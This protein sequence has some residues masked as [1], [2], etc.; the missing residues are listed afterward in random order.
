MKIRRKADASSPRKQAVRLLRQVVQAY[1]EAPSDA[2]AELIDLGR[3]DEGAREEILAMTVAVFRDDPG[4]LFPCWLALIVGEL[5]AGDVPLLLY[6][7]G[8]SEGDAL[9]AAI[10][11]SLIRRSRELVDEIGDALLEADKAKDDLYRSVL[12]D[13][14]HGILV[15]GDAA[16]KA[17]LREFALVRLDVER[18]HP[19][20]ETAITGPLFILA[21]L[22][23]PE[24]AALVGEARA[25]SEP[26]NDLHADLDD[27]ERVLAG[28]DLLDFARH[29]LA[30]DWRDTARDLEEL[31]REEEDGPCGGEE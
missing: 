10:I 17:R 6:G 1:D 25:L 31:A 5:D 12:Y 13:V 30:T 15:A 26:G 16:D 22:A 2:M 28:E 24:T 4:T 21:A 8:A 23:Y 19:R 27:I 9:N 29:I 18:R 20:E 3:E 7:I 11:A 14:L